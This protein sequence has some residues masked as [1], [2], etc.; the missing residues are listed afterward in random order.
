MTIDHTGYIIYPD[1]YWFR[2]A[3]R[4]AFPIFCFL[5]VQGFLHTKDDPKRIGKYLLRLGLFALISEIPF[6]KCF[7]HV[8]LE[9]QSQNVFITL[10]L[11]LLALYGLEKLDEHYLG[12]VP[13]IIAL[14]LSYWMKSDYSYLGIFMIFGF[15]AIE[16]CCDDDK[17][18][19]MALFAII[20]VFICGELIKGKANYQE[21]YDTFC[22]KRWFYL[23]TYFAII[24]LM[25]YNGERG[26]KNKWLKLAF[27]AYYPAHLLVL[28]HFYVPYETQL[29]LKVLGE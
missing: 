4:L 21:V 28:N 24:P 16:I 9:Y 17:K 6:D 8:T 12:F 23:G 19:A 22:E 11:G 15:Y 13:P 20:T 26:F 3:G 25:M 14:F 1:N 2:F 7:H 27:Y 5:I 10:F 18:K 29:L